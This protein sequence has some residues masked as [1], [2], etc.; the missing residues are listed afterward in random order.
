[1]TAGEREPV[2]RAL[3]VLVWISTHPDPPW[4]VRSVA[5]ELGTSPTTV[6][7]I[8]GTFESR[9]LLERD[10]DGGYV[11]GLELFRMCH[12]VAAQLSPARLVRPHLE[13]LASRVGETVMLGVYNPKRGEMMYLDVV[14]SAHPV[15][16]MIDKGIWQKVHAGATGLA[17]LS[18]LPEAERRAVY[19]RGLPSLTDRTVT[20]EEDLELTAAQIRQIGWV[21]TRGQRTVGAVGTAAPVFDAAGEVFGDVCVTIPE[22]RF[23]DRLTEKVGPAVA[24][25][26]AVVSDELRRAGY[27]R[28]T[29]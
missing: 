21:S 14:Q 10:S 23:D 26:A 1:M 28:G 11:P 9:G 29:A 27:R 3:D 17:I 13:A 7:R 6:H 18:F 24:E 2:G 25:T 5:R 20:T 19:Q 8:F 4:S 16:Y 22:Q 12:S 15:R